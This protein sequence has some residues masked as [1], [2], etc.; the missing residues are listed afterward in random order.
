[1]PPRM[2]EEPPRKRVRPVV[3]YGGH[4][5]TSGAPAEE[6]GPRQSRP[7]VL[8][9]VFVVLAVMGWFL[10]QNLSRA[11]K[12]QDCLMSGRKNCAPIDTSG[13]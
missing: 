10:I 5:N 1:M 13:K 4:V 6:D 9:L 2:P 11:S 3:P 7:G 12:E 8:L